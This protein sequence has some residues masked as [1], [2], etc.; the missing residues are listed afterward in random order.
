MT[1]LAIILPTLIERAN[2]APLIARIEAS[3]GDT[4]WEAVVVDDDSADGTADEA[5]ATWRTAGPARPR[6]SSASAGAGWR[7]RRSRA[8]AP[9][10]R[11]SSQ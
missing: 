4:A 7:A 8:P 11:R 3:L 10:P 2:L 9:P 1:T 5:P 6:S